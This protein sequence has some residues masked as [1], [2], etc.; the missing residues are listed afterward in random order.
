MREIE[1]DFFLSMLLKA[2]KVFVFTFI[3]HS[4][5]E[6]LLDF[7]VVFDFLLFT[8]LTG[9]PVDLFFHNNSGQKV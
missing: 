7:F 5:S 1:I 4:E 8:V 6:K 3:Y 9:N 2:A